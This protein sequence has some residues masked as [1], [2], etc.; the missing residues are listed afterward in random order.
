MLWNRKHEYFVHS[1]KLTTFVL[2][3]LFVYDMFINKKGKN[4]PVHSV[5]AIRGFR[6]LAPFILNLGTR[7]SWICYDILLW[8]VRK[9][10]KIEAVYHSC[11]CN[12]LLGIML[13]HVSAFLKSL[14]RAMWSVWRKISHIAHWNTF[15]YV[16]DVCTL[17]L[18]V[19][20]DRWNRLKLKK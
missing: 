19:C 16:V 12:T 5:A 18:Y 2:F 7:S 13:L 9:A 1:N 3:A 17:H 14:L 15:F 8:C 6:G 10:G 11:V 4:V 20:C